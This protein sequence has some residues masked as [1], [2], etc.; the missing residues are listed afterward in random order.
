MIMNTVVVSKDE[1]RRAVE[2]IDPLLGFFEDHSLG[3]EAF[4]KN[5]VLSLIGDADEI[6]W[7]RQTTPT[8]LVV[9]LGEHHFRFDLESERNSP[10]RR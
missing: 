1:A 10:Y 4:T 9:H 7:D 6:Y 3:G 5:G 2:Q 8:T